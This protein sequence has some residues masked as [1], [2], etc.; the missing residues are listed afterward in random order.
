MK[1]YFTISFV[2]NDISIRRGAKH[3]TTP[4]QIY[5]TVFHS[6]LKT[7]HSKCQRFESLLSKSGVAAFNPNHIHRKADRK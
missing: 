2:E 1:T 6:T 5:L 4:P 7:N 3:L